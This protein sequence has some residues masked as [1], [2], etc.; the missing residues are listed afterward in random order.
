MS[1]SPPSPS[2]NDPTSE[3]KTSP[4]V[5]KKNHNKYRKPKPWDNDTIDHWKQEAWKPEYMNGSLL[6]ES[7]FA[8]LFPKYRETYLRQ[9]WPLITRSLDS[10][11]ISCTLDLLEGSM[12]VSTTRGTVDPYIILKARDLIKLLARSIPAEQALKVLNDDLQCDVIKI[13][14]LVRNK[15]RFVKR[16]QRLVGPDGATLKALELLTNCYILVQGN[17]V[18]VMGG[19]KGL[20]EARNV[21]VECFKNVHPVYN[22]KRLM[23]KR[24]LAKDSKLANV[25]WERF[26][27]SFTKKNVQTKK[28][29]K[30]TDKKV[31]TPFP[32][33]QA[34]SKVDM[35][36]D[37]GEYFVNE[38]EREAVKRREKISNAA[39]NAGERR[40]VN[41]KVYEK[42]FKEV[43]EVGVGEVERE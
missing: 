10:H 3:T 39:K 2:P 15:E 42:G 23:I 17:T 11:K 30:V 38:R 34:K 37:S 14:G 6:E 28:P 13:G 7:S 5:T 29:R 24:E 16:R 41:E 1:S 12:S 9:T 27:P 18:A 4:T 43:E 22:I 31:Y 36:L 35:Q 33:A 8:T 20:K 26:L 21:I 25:N 32:N 19:Y 40:K